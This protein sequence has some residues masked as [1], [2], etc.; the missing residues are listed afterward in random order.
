MNSFS[1]EV[2]APPLRVS[3][4]GIAAVDEHVAFLEQ[5]RDF[6][7]HHIDR[8]AGLDHHHDFARLL[9]RAQQLLDRAGRLNVFSFRSFGGKFLRDFPGAIE[10]GDGKPLRFHVQDQVFAHDRETD[11]SDITLIR[12]HFSISL[13]TPGG[14]GG[15]DSIRLL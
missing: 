11:Q 9:Q 10:D 2:L 13:I 6:A 15:R 7:D 8:F 12:A 5:R 4:K 14:S 1:F 3:E